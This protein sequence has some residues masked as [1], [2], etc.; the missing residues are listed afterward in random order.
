MSAPDPP[1]YDGVHPRQPP[2]P[3]SIPRMELRA[4]PGTVSIA[5]AIAVGFLVEIA[6]G[7]WRNEARLA[8]LG[9]VVPSLFRTHEYW[10]LIT[11]LFLHGDGT[12]L[13]DALHLGLN[14]LALMQLGSLY[15]L[16]FGTRRFLTIYFIAGIFASVCSAMPMDLLLING[17]GDATR[18]ATFG[19]LGVYISSIRI[20]H[21]LS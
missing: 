12:Y 10:R 6:T 1:P 9:A 16:M 17:A 7:A 21:T 11:A 14:F 8:A 5:V 2:P 18:A 3:S 20:S 19:N 15:E 13:G 4:I